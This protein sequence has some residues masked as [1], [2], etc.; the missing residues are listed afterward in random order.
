MLYSEVSW[1]G[2]YSQWMHSI[3][4]YVHYG[5]FLIL[6]TVYFPLQ[7]YTANISHRF[8]I[9]SLQLLVPF[10]LCMHIKT[11]QILGQIPQLNNAPL[12]RV[13][14]I[15]IWEW[16]S[17]FN[18]SFISVTIISSCLAYD[19]TKNG[20]RILYIQWWCTCCLRCYSNNVIENCITILK[21]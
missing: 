2:F 1:C 5:P 12:K 7:L 9:Y 15:D 8:R 16:F 4:D 19:A 20:F 6:T 11:Y 21:D 14:E 17:Y 18:E 3:D 10:K 13:E